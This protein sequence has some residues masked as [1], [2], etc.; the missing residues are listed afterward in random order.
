MVSLSHQAKGGLYLNL[1]M[2]GGGDGG[3]GGGGGGGGVHEKPI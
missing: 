3:G 1:T 2:R